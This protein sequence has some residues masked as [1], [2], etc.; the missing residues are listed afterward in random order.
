MTWLPLFNEDASTPKADI[1][2]FDD[3]AARKYN[4]PIGPHATKVRDRNNRIII[5]RVQ[6]GVSN[7][8]TDHT[9]L[10]IFQMRE[11]GI[12]ADDIHKDHP[13]SNNGDKG[14]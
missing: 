13:R 2:G 12:I 9:L 1:I 5:L 8:T 11:L 10:C 7:N 14:S 4:L 6:H 3:K